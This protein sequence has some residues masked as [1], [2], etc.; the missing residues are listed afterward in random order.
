MAPGN[1]RA[2]VPGG[3]WRRAWRAGGSK[4]SGRLRRIALGAD[5]LWTPAQRGPPCLG[6][7]QHARGA[8]SAASAFAPT[9]PVQWQSP[10]R[11]EG[12]SRQSGVA[13]F[14]GNVESQVLAVLLRCAHVARMRSPSSCV[15]NRATEAHQTHPFPNM[16]SEMRHHRYRTHKR[17]PDFAIIRYVPNPLTD[18]PIT[19]HALQPGP[20]LVVLSSHAPSDAGPASARWTAERRYVIAPCTRS[21]V[22]QRKRA[23][24]RRPDYAR[25]PAMMTLCSR[26]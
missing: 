20:G 3:Q 11:N 10:R 15:Q 7:D 23:A 12:R 5:R 14:A 4:W 18:R 22:A 19:V 26:C 25:R 9:A 6:S 8:I 24:H 2:E 1:C 16:E 17:C 21:A 13:R